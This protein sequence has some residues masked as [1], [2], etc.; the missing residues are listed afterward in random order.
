MRATLTIKL[1]WDK[2][3]ETLVQFRDRQ[4]AFKGHV[5]RMQAN[6]SLPRGEIT[7]IITTVKPALQLPVK[8]PHEGTQ[9]RGGPSCVHMSGRQ[10]M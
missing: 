10:L 1:E 4:D 6:G 2:P 8:L 3:K 7:W 5:M 9:Y